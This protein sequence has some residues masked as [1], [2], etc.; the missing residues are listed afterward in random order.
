MIVLKMRRRRRLLTRRRRLRRLRRLLSHQ[1]Q[2]QRFGCEKGKDGDVIGLGCDL[3]KMQMHVSLNGNFQ[4]P[5]GVFLRSLLKHIALKYRSPEHLFRVCVFITA[6]RLH[7]LEASV[8]YV[9]GKR[10]AVLWGGTMSRTCILV[11]VPGTCV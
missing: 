10:L 3:D 11:V 8:A 4:A 9:V 1:A 2:A 5:Q 7:L 6:G